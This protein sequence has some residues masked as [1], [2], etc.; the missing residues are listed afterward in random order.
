[1][2]KN[3]CA[4]L[5]A[6]SS[7]PDFNRRFW[8]YTKSTDTWMASGRGLS[9]PVRNYTDP[10]TTFEQRLHYYQ[11]MTNLVADTV[12][13]APVLASVRIF[14]HVIGASVWV[15]G[16]L[17]LAALVP[18]LKKVN[19]D[20]PK[21]VANKF[22][23]LAWG[24][25]ALLIASGIWNMAALPKN[26]PANYSMVL[27]FKMAIVLLSGLAALIHS[28]AK[29][30]KKMALWGSISGLTALAALYLGVLLAG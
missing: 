23:K 3:T 28:R 8:N 30:P 1:M 2:E 11:S 18:A 14:I 21:I 27:G 26:P 24:A 15:G 25:Y 22:N 4:K 17:V 12:Q 10:G 7:H 29:Q 6:R 16:Q 13:L 20:L 19:P 9:P 5:K